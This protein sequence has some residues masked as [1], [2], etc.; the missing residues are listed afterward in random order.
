M[1]LDAARAWGTDIAAAKCYCPL[2]DQF[3]IEWVEEP[4]DAD[5]LDVYADF[6]RHRGSHRVAAGENIRSASEAR[7]LLD[8]GGIGV[9]QVDCGRIGGIGTAAE[10]ARYAEQRGAAYV[11]H[12]YTSHLALSAALQPF[13]GIE[14]HDL[15]EYPMDTSSLC[16][17][18]CQT[19]LTRDG[20]GTVGVADAPGLGIA[21]DLHAVEH[22]LVDLEIRIGQTTLY[23]TPSLR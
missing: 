9:L 13:A 11:N 2:L 15:C 20:D 3:G 14:R 23:R 7:Q 21:I 8:I 22:Y 16:W 4:F 18:I 5:A 17:A 6:A 1:F 12:T 10:L 19:H